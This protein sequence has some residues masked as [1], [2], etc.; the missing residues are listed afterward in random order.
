[1]EELLG[2]AS[3]G[4]STLSLFNE[5]L[6]ENVYSMER[7]G[8]EITV[9]FREVATGVETQASSINE[10][11]HSTR[12]V[13]TSV[14][15]LSELFR[16]LQETADE[17]KEWI[18]EGNQQ[19]DLLA[20][21]M[22]QVSDIID[23]TVTTMN[24]LNDQNKKIGDILNAINEISAQTNLLALNAAIEAARAGENGR[25]FAVVAEEV[26]KLAEDSRQSTEEISAILQEIQTQTEHLTTQVHDG[27]KTIHSSKEAAV[28]TEEILKKITEGDNEIAA[29]SHNLSIQMSELQQSS[30]AIV[31]ATGSISSV[32]VESSAALE[33][34][35]AIIEE[36]Q[37][38][39]ENVVKSFNQLE[40]LIG[41][42]KALTR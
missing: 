14:E 32:T 37:T 26:R 1:V 38:R 35:L 17:R 20:R 36:Q 21:E 28:K 6:T 3:E 40:D 31:A 24:R 19:V 5:N 12:N 34:V 30:Q 22:E 41:Q 7:I 29:R 2:K 39:I 18:R 10:L 33:Q 13:G 23:S 27:Q 42:L 15:Y 16:S 9:A 25:G 8:K 4:V 11:N